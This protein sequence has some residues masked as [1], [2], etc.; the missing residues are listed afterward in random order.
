MSN[1][2]LL[3][4]I[5]PC[6]NCESSIINALNSIAGK[7]LDDIEIICIDDC[8]TDNTPEVIKSYLSRTQKKVIFYSNANNLGAA[9]TRNKGIEISSAEFVV[10]LDSDDKFT[11]GSIDKMIDIIKVEKDV[12]IFDALINSKKRISMFSS[13]K[14]KPGSVSS[15]N[16]FVYTKGATWGK[17]YKRSLIVDN[18]IKFGDLP[19]NEDLVF[20]KECLY[21]ANQIIYLDECFYDYS[22]KKS[23]NSLM[24]RFGNSNE[25]FEAK[26]FDIIRNFVDNS[27]WKKELNSLFF[28]EVMYSRCKRNVSMRKKYSEARKEFGLLVKSYEKKDIYF[29]GYC[30]RYKFAYRLFRLWFCC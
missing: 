17:I 30:F 15:K 21:K 6:Y 2:I 14:I 9:A 29:S 24:A 10:F 16:A 7:D 11:N 25:D 27:Y 13:K 28:L 20:T 19:I 3:S 5:I 1:S 26:A 4:I 8:S 23:S 12:Y 18:D 22:Y